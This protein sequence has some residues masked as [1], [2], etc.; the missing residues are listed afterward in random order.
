VEANRERRKILIVED[1]QDLAAMWAVNL[2]RHQLDVTQTYSRKGALHV[3]E[4]ESPHVIIVDMHLPDGSGLDVIREAKKKNP[5][6]QCLVVSGL[7]RKIYE[8]AALDAGAYAYLQ[9]PCWWEHIEN[10]LPLR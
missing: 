9:K 8:Q 1:D 10:V 6:V 5:G 4:Q 2:S 7:P 3:L